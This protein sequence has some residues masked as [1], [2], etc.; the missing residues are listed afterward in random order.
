MGQK[1]VSDYIKAIIG[2]EEI[3]A[4]AHCAWFSLEEEEINKML[5][6]FYLQRFRKFFLIFKMFKNYAYC[7][8][9]TFLN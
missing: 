6:H 8:T 7:F 4:R 1:K 5:K 9:I 2:I 3:P